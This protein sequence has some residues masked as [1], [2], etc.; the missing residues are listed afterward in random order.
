[1]FFRD[2]TGIVLMVQETDWVSVYTWVNVVNKF[3]DIL[4][5]YYTSVLE[6]S[7]KFL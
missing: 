6:T 1:M 5:I 7:L 2:I 3:N 4:T